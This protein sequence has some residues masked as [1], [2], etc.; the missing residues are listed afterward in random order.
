M[1]ESISISEDFFPFLRSEVANNDVIRD[2]NDH[3][4]RYSKNSE[5]CIGVGRKSLY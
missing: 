2:F 3:L 4:F 5:C 1:K